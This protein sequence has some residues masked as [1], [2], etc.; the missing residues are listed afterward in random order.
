MS[1]QGTPSAFGCSC[2]AP[3]PFA[4]QVEEA[5]GVYVATPPIPLPTADSST[6]WPKVMFSVTRVL[7]GPDRDTV[8]VR[9]NVIGNSSCGMAVSD[10]P[11]VLLV[12][13]DRL[14]WIGLCEGDHLGE[15]GV[16]RATELLGPGRPIGATTES[17]GVGWPWLVAIAL[18]VG[19]GGLLLRR[20]LVGRHRSQTPMGDER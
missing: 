13:P 1:L 16:T 9:V 19:A 4:D 8:P 12:A 6:P 7:K 18:G 2:N 17:G 20:R 10:R 3:A 11:Y 5:D 15:D 14:P